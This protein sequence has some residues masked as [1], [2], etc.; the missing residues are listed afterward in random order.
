MQNI[1]PLLAGTNQN[2]K[3]MSFNGS[4]GGTIALSTAS[5]WTENYRNANPRKTKA[6][7][8]GKDIINQIL[9]QQGCMGIRIYYGIDEN[10]N[11]QLV[12]VGADSNENDILDMVV[13]LS[14]PCPA[15]CGQSNDLNS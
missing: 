2:F 12:L 7:F 14:K 6:H 4:E 15:H 3:T 8:F 9:A 5:T 11:P 13:D 10:S 1:L